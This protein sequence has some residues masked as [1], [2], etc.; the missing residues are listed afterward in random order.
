MRRQ[1][2]LDSAKA[3]RWVDKFQGKNLVRGYSKWFGVDFLCAVKELRLLG[4]PIDAKRE[5]QLRQTMAGRAAARRARKQKEREPTDGHPE[6]DGTFAFIARYTSGG[7]PYGV[8]WEEMERIES[9]MG[10]EKGGQSLSNT[11]ATGVYSQEDEWF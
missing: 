8:T 2:R 6:W 7:L 5:D 1:A 3:T 11:L 9:W 4:L 10:D